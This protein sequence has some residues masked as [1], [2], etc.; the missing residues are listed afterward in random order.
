[1][2]N[3]R[4]MRFTSGV[5]W[6]LGWLTTILGCFLV[7]ATVATFPPAV[8]GVEDYLTIYLYLTTLSPGLGMILGGIFTVA[9]GQAISA[10][11]D[12]ASNSWHLQEIA[13]N[14]KNTKNTRYQIAEN[15]GHRAPTISLLSR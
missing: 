3:Y 2:K 1:M 12:M 9:F 8:R 4:T 10:V 14:T 15:T 7:F 5:F 13:E 6:V 11:A